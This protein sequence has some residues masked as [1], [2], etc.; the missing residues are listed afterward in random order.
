MILERVRVRGM[1]VIEVLPANCPAAL[2]LVV[3]D[4]EGEHAATCQCLRLVPSS[5]DLV[6]LATVLCSLLVVYAV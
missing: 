3:L 4:N 1:V 5:V 6:E 2:L